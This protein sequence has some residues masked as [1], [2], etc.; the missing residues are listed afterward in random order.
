MDIPYI[1]PLLYLANPQTKNLYQ[2]HP[3]CQTQLVSHSTTDFTRTMID[4]TPPN[5]PFIRRRKLLKGL[6]LRYPLP[7]R[8]ASR[9]RPPEP[10]IPHDPLAVLSHSFFPRPTRSLISK[11]YL[12]AVF[13]LERPLIY[14]PTLGSA[15]RAVGLSKDILVRAGAQVFPMFAGAKWRVGVSASLFALPSKW[16]LDDKG[17]E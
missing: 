4:Y 2:T 15:E 17:Y 11:Q 1:P 13:R 7:P 3:P 9:P 14:E 16:S 6:R 10:E 8:A 12:K 5:S